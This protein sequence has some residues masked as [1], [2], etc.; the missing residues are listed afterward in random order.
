[1]K[2]DNIILLDLDGVLIPTKYWVPDKIHEDGYSDF[3]SSCV[4]NLNRIIKETGYDIILSSMRRE[5]VD[6]DQMNIY[7]KNRGVDSIIKSYVPKYRTE[8]IWYDRRREIEMFLE[9]HKPENYLIIDDDKSL[10]NASEEIKS[11]WIRTKTMI[12]L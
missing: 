8:T 6:I 1:M 10:L 5:Q 4:A 9:E 11:N 7:F 3:N 2:L 12:G